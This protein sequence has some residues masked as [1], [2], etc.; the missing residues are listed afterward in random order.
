MDPRAVSAGLV[1]LVLGCASATVAADPGLLLIAERA[2]VAVE[3]SR[4]PPGGYTQS[5]PQAPVPKA[6]SK[7]VAADGLPPESVEADV[8]T[9][10][11]AITSG[12]TGTEII[13]F[14]TVDNSRQES[15]EAGYYDV[16]IV[17]EGIPT[18]LVAR[19]KSNVAGIWLNTS[20]VRFDN[21]PS[22]YAI[23]TTQPL[24][25]IADP[26]VLADHKIG[27]EYVTMLP[28]RRQAAVLLDQELKEYEKAVVR[29]K[30]RDGLYVLD[31]YSVVFIG[32]SL[33]RSSI[34][35]PANVPVGPLTARVYLFRQGQLLSEYTARVTLNRQGI[36]RI[37]YEAATS[38][39]L[40]YGLVTVALAVG[41]GLL[42]SAIFGR[43]AHG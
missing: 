14:G 36:E 40:L 27:F 17:V 2:K 26:K 19:R 21:V 13:V 9:R 39:P 7:P 30:Q 34:D 1:A 12:F 37:L 15:A 43:A 4:R 18:A 42:A 11:V 35:L 22:Y 29:L 6:P 23:A 28:G 5:Q 3:R 38:F 31:D 20:S 32:R 25:E 41:A 16:I 8:S 24:E 10:S 33:F